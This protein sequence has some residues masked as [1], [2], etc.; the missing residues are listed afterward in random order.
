MPSLRDFF[1]PGLE[2]SF[3]WRERRRLVS[4]ST[5]LKWKAQKVN[6]ITKLLNS[7]TPQP[8]LNLKP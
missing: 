1:L 5:A 2:S 8:T 4:L 3:Q 6:E 7:S